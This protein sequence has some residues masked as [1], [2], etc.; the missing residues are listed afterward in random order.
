MD[1][2]IENKT[3]IF[4]WETPGPQG[5]FWSTLEDNSHHLGR[6]FLKVFTAEEIA[7]MPLDASLDQAGKHAQLHRLAK[8][9]W[10]NDPLYNIPDPATLGRADWLAWMNADFLVTQLD[11]NTGNLED[12]ESRLLRQAELYKRRWELGNDKDMTGPSSLSSGGGLAALYLRLG[13]L[14]DAEAVARADMPLFEK[15]PLLGPGPSPQSLGQARFLMEVV[16]KQGRLEEAT[17]MNKNGYVMIEELVN[18]KFVKYKAEEIEAMDEVARNLQEWATET[19]STKSS[20]P[21][22]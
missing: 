5:P 6:Q 21:E 18:G 8:E 14:A 17:M 9:R 15:H 4:P 10:D 13:R 19:S 7:A 1:M 3:N 16:A 11:M 12:A 22:T 20:A 2:E